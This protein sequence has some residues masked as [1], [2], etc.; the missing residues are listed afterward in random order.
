VNTVFGNFGAAGVFGVSSG[1]GGYG[2][3]FY[4]SN[5]SGTGPALMAYASGNGNGIT[6]T[7]ANSGN[8]VESSISGTGN[9]FYGWVPGSGTGRAAHF[10]NYNSSNTTEALLVETRST[11][12]LAVF[13]QGNPS[14]ANKARIDATGKVFA[15]G[16]F[17]SS[18]ADVAEAFDVTGMR[19]N[20][21]PGDVLIIST[22]TDRAVEKSNEA[23]SS[24][25]AGVYATRPGIVLTEEHIDTNIDNKV[26]MGVV[27]VLPT[28]V[29][30]EGG[31][32]KRGDMLVTS[33]I[34]GV[35]MKADPNKVKTGQVI[36]K[37]L[38]DYNEPGIGKIN[39]LVSIK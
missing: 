24:L 1:T 19:N 18:G 23:Y 4:A 39:V 29:C 31:A 3:L 33:S 15:N 2:G 17:Q 13:K 25:V 6:S 27:G 22:S 21:E 30:I 35:A 8:G 5:A 38:Q 16:G 9:A 12:N 36:G 32:I 20:Y 28:K 14:T 26:P 37:A 11:G 10:L 7:A 34:T